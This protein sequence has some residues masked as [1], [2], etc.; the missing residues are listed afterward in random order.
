MISRPAHEAGELTRQV[1]RV[2]VERPTRETRRSPDARSGR[3]G[4]TRHARK[5]C[6]PDRAARPRRQ[7][8]PRHLDGG[9]RG[10]DLTRMRCLAKPR[11][12]IDH[13]RS[14]RRPATRPRQCR[15]I[16]TLRASRSARMRL[17]RQLG[18]TAATA[19]LAA[20]K[21][22]KM[23]SPSPRLFTTTHHAHARR[24]RAARH[25]G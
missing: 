9:L 13:R 24:P 17:Q 18:A 7:R 3:P 21:T 16:R 11:A 2:R 22:A 6:S 8:L 20:S 15:A 5:R 25:A 1:R 12:A 14:S 4:L 23:L 19:A 10:E